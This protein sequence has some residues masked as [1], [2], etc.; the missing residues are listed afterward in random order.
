MR[1]KTQ[2]TRQ[3][4]QQPL[5]RMDDFSVKNRQKAG[6]LARL[7]KKSRLVGY[8]EKME[9]V[10]KGKDVKDSNIIALI[11]HAVSKNDSTKLKG[12]NRFYNLLWQIGVPKNL[13]Q[14]KFG[15][16]LIK[17]SFTISK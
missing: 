3:Q 2:Q 7:L 10:Y 5:F 9:M 4:T 16:S 11:E 8:N 17:K 15:R 6:K 1:K 13:I 12:M 14:N